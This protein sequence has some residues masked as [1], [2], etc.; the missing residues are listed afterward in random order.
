MRNV[1]SFF[2]KEHPIV[3]LMR[4]MHGNQE[5]NASSLW[6]QVSGRA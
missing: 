1:G 4:D 3:V 5:G 2:V 6:G